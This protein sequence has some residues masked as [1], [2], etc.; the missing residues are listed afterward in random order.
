[1]TNLEDIEQI[2]KAHLRNNIPSSSNV[3]EAHQ[4]TTTLIIS[5][6]SVSKH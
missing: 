1:M 5:Y 4:Y 2:F 6:N 3:S